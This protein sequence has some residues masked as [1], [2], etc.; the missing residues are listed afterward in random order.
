MTISSK[1]YITPKKKRMRVPTATVS[2]GLMLFVTLP[3]EAARRWQ[4]PVPLGRSVCEVAAGAEAAALKAI[5][6][7]R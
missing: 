6:D 3:A 5:G 2:Y 1:P 4:A 7:K